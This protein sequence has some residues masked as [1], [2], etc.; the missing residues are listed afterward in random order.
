MRLS[1]LDGYNMSD[2]K[3]RLGKWGRARIEVGSEG[4]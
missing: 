4:R 2:G 3:A 1:V